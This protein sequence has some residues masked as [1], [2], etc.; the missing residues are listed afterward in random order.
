MSLRRYTVIGKQLL[1]SNDRNR[2][3]WA[4]LGLSQD[5]VCRDSLENF[6]VKSLKLD[7]SNDTKFNPPFFSLVNAFKQD[8]GGRNFAL[9]ILHFSLLKV[10]LWA[11][12][13]HS[14][15]QNAAVVS[16]KKVTEGIFKISQ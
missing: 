8:F 6:S 2:V 12:C 7:Q 1:I 11:F 3:R 9:R 4:I 10:V 13:E 14:Q 5:G 16:L 15:G